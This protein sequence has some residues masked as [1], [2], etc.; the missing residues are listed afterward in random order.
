MRSLHK[1]FYFQHLSSAYTYADLQQQ[2][3]HLLGQNI[4]GHIC[5][6]HVDTV[7]MVNSIRKID[8]SYVFSFKVKKKIY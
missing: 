5:Q 7:G 8:K 2:Q 3:Q 4:S 1:S 6:G